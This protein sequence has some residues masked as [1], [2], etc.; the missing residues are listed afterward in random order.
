MSS[1]REKKLFKHM[2]LKILSLVIAII[3]WLVIMNIDDYTM[4]RTIRNIP[5]VQLNGDSITDLGK[6]Y[7]V[8]SGNTVDIVVKGPRTVVD[9]LNVDSFTAT[10]DLSELSLTN[11]AQITVT[12]NDSRINSQIEISY[13]NRTVNLTVEDKVMKEFPIKAVAEGILAEG[14]ALGGCTV[15]PNIIQIDGPE[16][17]ISRVTEVR[18]TVKVD[19]QSKTTEAIVVPQCMNAYG[20]LVTSKSIE[21]ET[22]EVRVTATIYPTKEVPVLIEQMGVP[23]T[24]YMVTGINY[25]PQ[26]ITITGDEKNLAA[27]DKITLP[28]KDLTGIDT[29]VEMN[30]GVEEYLPKGIYLAD[31]N[32]QVAINVSVEGLVTKDIEIAPEDIDLRNKAEGLDYAV[33][34]SGVYRIRLKGLEQDLAEVTK[35]SLDIY[36][37][38]DGKSEG[39]YVVSPSYTKP[40]GV[41]VAL[42]G[43]MDLQV[44]AKEIPTEEGSSEEASSEEGSS[45]ELTETTEEQT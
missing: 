16:S 34:I 23:A 20:E 37:N 41:T 43:H 6:V 29:D 19:N 7:D 2:G 42:S 25:N 36:L 30:I 39:G 5:V 31:S 33:V 1:L 15:T 9:S 45:E 18:A 27:V 44:T 26:T 24:D 14:Y 21:L 10:A 4:T 38:V 12:A 35:E 8:T 17:I 22:K 11:S 28:T 3:L 13:V 32:D 40:S